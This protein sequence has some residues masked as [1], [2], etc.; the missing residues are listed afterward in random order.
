MTVKTLLI[1]ILAILSASCV[2]PIYIRPR[3][4][5]VIV[6]EPTYYNDCFYYE[7][8]CYFPYYEQPVVIYKSHDRDDH[9]ERRVHGY[10]P[11]VIHWPVRHPSRTAHRKSGGH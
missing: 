8:F 3:P 5:P 10:N 1:A 11:P 7:P 4:R 9:G 2:E 6:V